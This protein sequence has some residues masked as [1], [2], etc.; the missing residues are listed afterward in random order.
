MKYTTNNGFFL[1]LGKN[2]AIVLS[3]EE[4]ES[5]PLKNPF[6]KLSEYELAKTFPEALPAIKMSIKI[7]KEDLY[8][9]IEWKRILNNS[10]GKEL[11]LEEIKDPHY[12]PIFRYFAEQYPIDVLNK[13]I[14]SL[15]RI[16]YFITAGDKVVSSVDSVEKAKQRPITDFIKIDRGVACCLWHSE[17][18]PSMHYYKDKN[19]VHCFGCGKDEDVIG[20]VQ[21]VFDVGFLKAISI[22]NN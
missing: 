17:K 8:N 12:T 22:I 5:I 10:I 1:Q 13:K 9:F 15:E 18:S 16:K 2:R 11:E 19:R 7:H 20:V 3:P 6:V 4:I 21:K 14:E